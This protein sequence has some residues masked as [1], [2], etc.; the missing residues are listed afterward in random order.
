MVIS[1][2]NV[3]DHQPLSINKL[4][5]AAILLRSL[6]MAAAK[7]HARAQRFGQGEDFA[8]KAVLRHPAGQENAVVL[9][10]NCAC[11]A[12]AHVRR[13]RPPCPEKRTASSCSPAPGGWIGSFHIQRTH[14]CAA[15]PASR[16][17]GRQACA[18]S[19]NP[20][21]LRDACASCK[22]PQPVVDFSLNPL[23][24]LPLALQPL[25]SAGAACLRCRP[26]RGFAE[27]PRSPAE[28]YPARADTEWY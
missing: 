21:Q 13:S 18:P 9:A 20:I 5:Q 23:Q 4:H 1:R 28:A 11:S 2:E 27:N 8:L 24:L 15:I 19:D 7:A 10:R 17:S 25:P 26:H 6:G 14:G 16:P 3:A 12:G 22:L